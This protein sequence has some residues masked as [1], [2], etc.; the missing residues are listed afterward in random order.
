MN[1]KVGRTQAVGQLVFRECIHHANERRKLLVVD[2]LNEGVLGFGIAGA[3]Y[4]SVKADSVLRQNFANVDK[5]KR[6]LRVR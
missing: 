5:A 3:D 4:L 6:T 2:T 1:E